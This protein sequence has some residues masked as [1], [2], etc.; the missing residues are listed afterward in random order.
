MAKRNYKVYTN[1]GF[2]RRAIR[3]YAVVLDNG[4]GSSLI[5]KDF[6]PT[7]MWNRIKP[8]NNINVM[9]DNNRKVHT[10]GTIKLAVEIGSCGDG[11]LRCG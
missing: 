4:A 9:E 5:R 11:H 3:R 10:S 8:T 7:K 6:I 1:I 2:T